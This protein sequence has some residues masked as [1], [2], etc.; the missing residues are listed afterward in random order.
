MLILDILWVYFV[1]GPKYKIQINTI[2]NSPLRVNFWYASVA[3]VL[4]TLGLLI[5]CLPNIKKTQ[6][7]KT[8]LI[9]GALFGLILYGVYD[10][11]IASVIKEWNMTTAIIDII[12]GTFVFGFVCLMSSFIG[13]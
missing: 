10:F 2:Q 5:F 12:W 1:M 3:Y 11:T 6:R 8:S 7:W 13:D 4:M 9:Y